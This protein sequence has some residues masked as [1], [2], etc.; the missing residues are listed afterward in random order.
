[1]SARL[2]FVMLAVF[3]GLSVASMAAA[4]E[5]HEPTKEELA[6]KRAYLRTAARGLVEAGLARERLVDP[7]TGTVHQRLCGVVLP[8]HPGVKL[9]L[10]REWDST[11][12]KRLRMLTREDTGLPVGTARRWDAAGAL[13]QEERYDGEGRLHGRCWYGPWTTP[14]GEPRPA[15]ALDCVR[16]ECAEVTP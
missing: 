4:Q 13:N 16:G 7:E 1:M 8:I 15:K 6:A 10:H 5:P 3:W 2:F 12:V 9:C 11:G 14:E